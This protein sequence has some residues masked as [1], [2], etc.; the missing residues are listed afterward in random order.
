MGEPVSE[1]FIGTEQILNQGFQ[2]SLPIFMNI[3]DKP[4]PEPAISVYPNPVSV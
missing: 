3:K 1:T 4:D 2:Q